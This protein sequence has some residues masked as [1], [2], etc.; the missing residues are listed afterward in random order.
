MEAFF[1]PPFQVIQLRH[2]GLTFSAQGHTTGERQNKK[3]DP[4]HSTQ[5]PS[6]ECTGWFLTPMGYRKSKELQQPNCCERWTGEA[7]TPEHWRMDQWGWG[8]N[9]VNGNETRCRGRWLIGC[10]SHSPLTL[11]LSKAFYFFFFCQ[12]SQPSLYSIPFD[13]FR[14][15]FQDASVRTV[16]IPV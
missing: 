11:P 16:I 4:G 14:G 7:G 3:T 10:F 6:Q 12:H 2:T 15:L 5:S 1:L 13:Y 9:K 8:G